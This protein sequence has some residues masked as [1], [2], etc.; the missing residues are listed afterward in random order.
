MPQ[1][2][3]DEVR[4]GAD[5][6]CLG[7]SADDVMRWSPIPLAV[8]ET[9]G[10]VYTRIERIATELDGLSNA[11]WAWHGTMDFAAFQDKTPDG[12]VALCIVPAGKGRIVFWQ[13]PPWFFDLKRQPQL[14]HSMRHAH[15][16]LARLLGNLGAGSS[17][18]LPRYVDGVQ[19]ED[20]PYRYFRW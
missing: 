12:N 6:L 11:D 18:A 16:L 1:G 9:N 14:R 17:V 5:V 13:T 20:D 19:I 7:F 4:S 15:V 10:C 8:A 3:M 2:L